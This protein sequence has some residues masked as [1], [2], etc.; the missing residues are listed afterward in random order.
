MTLQKNPN[1]Q[2]YLRARNNKNFPFNLITI[3]KRINLLLPWA[4][5][6]YRNQGQQLNLQ[7]TKHQFALIKDVVAQYKLFYRFKGNRIPDFPKKLKL[8]AFKSKEEGDNSNQ[9]LDESL[10]E[11]DKI[12]KV[13]RKAGIPEPVN[14]WNISKNDE[15]T[16]G[17]DEGVILKADPSYTPPKVLPKPV[18]DWNE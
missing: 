15:W 8:F 11:L 9:N 5:L 14:E 6:Y 3:K 18:D 10:S 13:H 1:Y 4:Y 2:Q 12:I 7:L 17:D 16:P